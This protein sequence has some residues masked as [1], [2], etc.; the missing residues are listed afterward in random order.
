MLFYEILPNFELSPL[1]CIETGDKQV[2][3]TE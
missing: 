1:K 3:C 2:N